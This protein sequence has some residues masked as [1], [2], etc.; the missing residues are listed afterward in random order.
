MCARVCVDVSKLFFVCFFCFQSRECLC[1]RDWAL[2]SSTSVR[3][4]IQTRTLL[5][6]FMKVMSLG[7]SLEAEFT[8]AL[9]SLLS[10]ERALAKELKY[11]LELQWH[12]FSPSIQVLYV[13]FVV[14]VVK[15]KERKEQRRE[16]ER[17]CNSCCHRATKHFMDLM[18][19]QHVTC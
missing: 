18:L 6:E 7:I 10:T 4:E 2:F 15:R 1:F 16:R 12:K 9:I 5:C 14:Y 3:S 13:V 11:H 17:E 8:H 19:S